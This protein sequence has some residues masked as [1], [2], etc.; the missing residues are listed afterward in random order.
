MQEVVEN[1][2]SFQQFSIAFVHCDMRLNHKNRWADIRR[3]GRQ[4]DRPDQTDSQ[5]DSQALLNVSLYISTQTLNRACIASDVTYKNVESHQ[6]HIDM[7][8]CTTSLF[9]C[10]KSELLYIA[11]IKSRKHFLVYFISTA[12]LNL[13]CCHRSTQI[14]SC[15][16]CNRIFQI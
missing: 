9:L 11:A 6:V 1:P 7:L 4:T 8:E 2:V 3:R 15:K 16:T 5:G 13:N 10:V 12:S 14:V